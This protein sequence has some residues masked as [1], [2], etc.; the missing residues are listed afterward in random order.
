MKNEKIQ[1]SGEDM[2]MSDFSE[3]V[4]LIFVT[5]VILGSVFIILFF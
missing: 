4:A 1:P 3:M 2:R 5:V